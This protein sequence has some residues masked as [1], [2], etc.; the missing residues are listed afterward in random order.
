MRLVEDDRIVLGQ[1]AAPGGD[2]RE[3]ERVIRDH[4]LGLPGASAGR[5][6][7]ARRKQRAAAPGA[8]VRADRK[9]GPERLGRL[10]R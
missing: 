2:I 8:T 6:R 1:H 4:E 3:V 9:L 7:E 10:E 5:F